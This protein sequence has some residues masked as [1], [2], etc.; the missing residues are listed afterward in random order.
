MKFLLSFLLASLPLASA[1]FGGFFEQMF[2]GQEGHG[3]GHGHQQQHNNPS[4]ANNYRTQ[5]EQCEYITRSL[6]SSQTDMANRRAR[7]SSFP[8]KLP[9]TSTSAPTRSPA[10]TSRTT[11][12]ARGMLTKISS[13]WEMARGS[14]SLKEGSRRAR[15]RGRLSWR[16]K[17]CYR[18]MVVGG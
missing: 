18:S 8:L 3:H 12:P 6:W 10:S 13:S 11:V 16:G 17:D 14:V 15:R 2:G 9:A 5:F 7:F 4:D 1:Q